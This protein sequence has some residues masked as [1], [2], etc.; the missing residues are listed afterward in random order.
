MRHFDRGSKDNPFS[1]C[2]IPDKTVMRGA[3]EGYVL[4]LKQLWESYAG[5]I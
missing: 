1:F 3:W 2:F 4:A 5:V